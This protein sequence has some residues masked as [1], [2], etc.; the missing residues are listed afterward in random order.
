MSSLWTG[1]TMSKII[2]TADWH[3]SDKTPICRRDNYQEMMGRKLSFINRI[4]CEYKGEIP[5]ILHAGD[6]FDTWKSSH[7]LV[8]WAIRHL[9]QNITTIPGN[10]EIP[11][12]NINF[13]K[14]TNLNVLETAKK[15]IVIYED[16]PKQYVISF[17][18]L[19]IIGFPYGY[20]S[21]EKLK[22]CD[23]KYPYILMIHEMFLH[24]M[25]KR[26]AFI[27]EFMPIDDLLN[28]LPEMC[29]G[30]LA[31]HNHSTIIRTGI[32]GKWFLNPGSI[33]RMDADQIDHIPTIFL[34]DLQK[35]EITPVEI[36]H[37]K[38][39]VSREHIEKMQVKDER[40]NSFVNRVN[41]NYTKTLSFE[42][43]MEQFFLKNKTRKPIQEIIWEGMNGN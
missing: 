12:H 14:K 1:N 30:V 39:A 21:L 10:H 36:P 43:N 23:T 6:L 38:D 40:I 31:G 4:Q 15:I 20:F 24:P 41:T 37:E 13:Y 17:D 27:Q 42:D 19:S 25:D 2:L 34:Y 22:T 3:L 35:N 8:S 32:N 16:D 33:F 28:S 9:P 18:G 26:R 7:F 29:V 5:L 11:G